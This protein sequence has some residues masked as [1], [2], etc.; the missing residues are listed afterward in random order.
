MRPPLRS[1]LNISVAPSLHRSTTL[2]KPVPLLA[3]AQAF[4]STFEQVKAIA[5][6]RPHNAGKMASHTSPQLCDDA[7]LPAFHFFARC[8]KKGTPFFLPFILP[9][10]SNQHTESTN[11]MK[12]ARRH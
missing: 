10:L 6:A 3:S 5:V 7:I 2:G 4:P 1:S 12:I 8:G 9:V 11:S